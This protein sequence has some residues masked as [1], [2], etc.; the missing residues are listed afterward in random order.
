MQRDYLRG[1]E[2]I[3]GAVNFREHGTSG[4][5]LYRNASLLLLAVVSGSKNFDARWWV[6][7]ALWAQRPWLLG[8]DWRFVVGTGVR[9][10][11]G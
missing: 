11:S 5:P 7:R 6:R 4:P 10:L 3:G 9:W 2:W 8:V 1:H